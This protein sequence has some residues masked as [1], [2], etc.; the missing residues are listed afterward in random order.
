LSENK[1]MQPMIYAFLALLGIVP[2]A[3]AQDN[4]LGLPAVP[5]AALASS[6]ASLAKPAA[7]SP[8]AGTSSARK[9]SSGASAAS[10]A[11]ASDAQAKAVLSGGVTLA[12]RYQ[13]S[14]A[15]VRVTTNTVYAS[16]EQRQAAAQAARLVQRDLRLVCGAQCKPTSMPA[17]LLL[18]DGKLQFDMAITP[19][20][21]VLSQPDMVAM[22]LGKPL[23]VISPAATASSA[24]APNSP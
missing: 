5:Q 23:A 8:Q 12:S 14:V 22:L 20:P 1:G 18:P 9:A 11:L 17:P 2:L 16:K 24:A 10:A 4:V 21:R 15:T 3:Q 13:G 19:Y 6:P 7:S